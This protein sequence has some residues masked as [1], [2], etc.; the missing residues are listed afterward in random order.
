MRQEI[1]AGLAM[2]FGMVPGLTVVPSLLVRTGMDFTGAYTACVLVSLAATAL[3]GWLRLP[4]AAAC[5]PALVGWLA[6]LVILSHGHS[7][8]AALGASFFASLL[9]VVF[10]ATRLRSYVLQAFPRHLRRL[11]PMAVGLMLIFLGLIQGRLLVGAPI[12]II[13]P[14]DLA[15]PVAFYSLVGIVLTVALLVWRKSFAIPLGMLLTAAYSFVGGFWVLPDAPF[16]LPEGLDR[17]AGQLCLAE[18][19]A[20]PEVIFVLAVFQMMAVEGVRASLWQRRGKS[21]SAAVCGASCVGTWAGCFPLVLAPESALGAAAGAKGR[22]AAWTA[23]AVLALCLFCEPV[24]ASFASFG[25][26]TAPALVGAGYALMARMGRCHM[27]TS[28]EH[29]SGLAL[30][31]ILPLTQDFSLGLGMAVISYGLVRLFQGEGRRVPVMVYVMS[32]VFF[33]CL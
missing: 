23:A 3:L 14:G 21:I 10:L 2:G 1:F 24:M 11:L 13:M 9:S 25:A 7:W 33:A 16:L 27:R 32:L 12:G 30:L 19:L 28:A 17:T 5:N 31:L 15:D 4:L 18:G 8:Q 20:M 6:Y 26:I 29:V 22:C